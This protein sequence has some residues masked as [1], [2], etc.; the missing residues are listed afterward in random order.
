MPHCELRWEMPSKEM[1]RTA[2]LLVLAVLLIVTSLIGCGPAAPTVTTNDATDITADSATLAGSLD[3]LGG[4]ATV[5]V[6]FVWGP[7]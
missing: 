1:S 4:Y 6:S 5:D 3:S 7:N 2:F